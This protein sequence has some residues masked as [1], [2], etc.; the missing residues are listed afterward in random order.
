MPDTCI[1][2]DSSVQL[3]NG[4]QEHYE[5]VVVVPHRLL[6]DAQW[7]DDSPL[8]LAD[9]ELTPEQY[10]DRTKLQPP[11]V[12]DFRQMLNSLSKKYHQILVILVSSHLSQAYQ[13]ACQAVDQLRGAATIQVIDSQTIGAGLGF[14]VQAAAEAAQ[15]GKPAAMVNRLVRG[16][17]PH[18]YTIFCL[19]SLRYLAA[20]GY[21]DPAQAAIG[22]MLG[23]IPFYVLDGGKLV[24]M[25]KARSM[26]QFVDVMH[27]FVS[28]FEQVNH[29]ALLHGPCSYDQEMHNLEERLAQELP[30]VPVT[31]HP[32]S[33]GMA[34][35]LGPRSFGVAVLEHAN[36][37]L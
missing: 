23:I 28:E 22:E 27:E 37:V 20:S 30:E 17:I 21:L 35:L 26:R 32:F 36:E 33:A 5:H 31:R 12:E 16:M 4:N 34:V 2:T 14:L 19:Q 10:T 18:V 9:L 24:P 11:S 1:L 25:Q 8:R 7:Q 3:F 15:E 29:I 6:V 13:N